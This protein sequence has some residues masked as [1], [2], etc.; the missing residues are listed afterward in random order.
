VWKG[1]GAPP[2]ALTGATPSSGPISGGT[3]VVLQGSG[4][5]A[6]AGVRFGGSPAAVVAS[7]DTSVTVTTPAHAAGRVDVVVS[8][9]DGRTATL[10][11]GFGYVAPRPPVPPAVTRLAPTSGPAA[12]GTEVVLAGSGFAE[13]AS[14]TFGGAPATVRAST[15]TSL[16]VTTPAQI[17]GRA[18]VVVSNPDGQKWMVAGG[19]EFT[20]PPP[21]PPIPPPRRPPVLPSPGP[22]VVV[23]V[24]D[25]LNAL[26]TPPAVSGD[27]VISVQ[28]EPFGDVYLDDRP[29]GV[30]PREF[31]VPAGTYLLRVVH[32]K[33]G[34]QEKRVQVRAGERA[35]WVADFSGRR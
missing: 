26:P 22:A 10:A 20:A 23:V 2:P 34:K 29:Y 24:R 31:R 27:G 16:T 3:S 19:Y 17:A 28:A 35:R 33:M 13:G 18:D 25:A 14:V 7:R 11:G 6:G 15:P 4:I 5:A 1:C 32:P 12:G 9:P 21:R 30:A 8:N